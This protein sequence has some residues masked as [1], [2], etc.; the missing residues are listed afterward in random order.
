MAAARLLRKHPGTPWGLSTSYGHPHEFVMRHLGTT[1]VPFSSL[2]YGS[3]ILLDNLRKRHSCIIRWKK[4]LRGTYLLRR[5][6]SLTTHNHYILTYNLF[7]NYN[8]LPIQ[9]FS[10]DI[11]E[12][13]RRIKT[14]EAPQAGKRHTI[15]SHRSSPSNSLPK[16]R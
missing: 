5:S 8:F 1:F 2:E 7:S 10:Q 13:G 9:V 14:L 12:Y 3:G 11:I 4:H 6:V 16:R 15:P